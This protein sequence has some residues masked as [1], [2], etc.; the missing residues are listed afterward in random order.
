MED[1]GSQT[2]ELSFGVPC[3]SKVNKIREME[4]EEVNRFCDWIGLHFDMI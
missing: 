2:S 3:A 1:L 4:K